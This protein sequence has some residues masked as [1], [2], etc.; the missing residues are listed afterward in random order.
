VEGKSQAP[1]RWDPVEPWFESHDHPFWK[2]DTVR[3]ASAGHGGMD[4]LEDWRLITCL[5]GGLPTDQ[6]VYDGAAWSVVGPLTEWSVKNGSR[7]IRI[8]DFT[9]GGWKTTEPLGIIAG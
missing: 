4:W 8:P 1:D 3:K 5:R 2:S 9:R 6:N 7:P